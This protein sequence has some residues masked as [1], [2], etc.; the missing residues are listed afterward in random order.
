[1]RRYVPEF[2]LTKS[3]LTMFAIFISLALYIGFA[4]LLN[5]KSEQEVLRLQTF[6]GLIENIHCPYKGAP[7]LSLKNSNITFRLTSNFGMNYCGS[8]ADTFKNNEVTLKAALVQES[9][10]QIYDMK[11]RNDVYLSAADVIENKNKFSFAMFALA[12]ILFLIGVYKQ[13]VHNK[14]MKQEN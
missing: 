8:K 1:M 10:F 9:Y 5:P 3:A 14:A 7:D 6:N 4:N 13:K 12:L 11:I 2:T